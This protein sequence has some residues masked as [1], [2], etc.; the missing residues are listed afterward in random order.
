MNSVERKIFLT[1]L[2]ER[3][4]VYSLQ[5]FLQKLRNKFSDNIATDDKK[6]SSEIVPDLPNITEKILD[7]N[8]TDAWR[9]HIDSLKKVSL[10]SDCISKFESSFDNDDM[11]IFFKSVKNTLNN[12][13]SYVD[14]QFKEPSDINDDTSEEIAEKTGS[15]VKNCIWDLLRGCHSGIKHSQGYEHYFYKNFSDCLE[16]YLSSIKVYRKDITEGSYISENAEWFAT[17]F[18]LESSITSQI[19]TIDEIEVAP[20]FIPYRDDSFERAEL[21][22]KGTCIVFGEM[23]NK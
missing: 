22:L 18:I 23:K 11:A 1:N 8:G 2:R 20:H 17:P 3:F 7:I 13:S 9:T 19:G 14:K 10:L 15:F 12:I 21:I 5:S 16:Q 6:E 4:G